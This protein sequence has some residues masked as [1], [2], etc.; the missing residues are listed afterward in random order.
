[1]K[2]ASLVVLLGM[3]SACDSA[4]FKADEATPRLVKTELFVATAPAQ[5]TTPSDEYRVTFSEPSSL[6]DASCFAVV[7]VPV[8]EPASN[9]A[10][11]SEL[12]VLTTNDGSV[13]LV[14][15]HGLTRETV[16]NAS[17]RRVSACALALDTKGQ[18]QVIVA[19]VAGD[20]S[21]TVHYRR[22]GNGWRP[23][24]VAPFAASQIAFNARG[25]RGSEVI[26][27]DAWMTSV[28]ALLV[29]GRWQRETLPT[30]AFTGA[31]ALAVAVTVGVDG[32]S[33]FALGPNYYGDRGDQ[34]VYWPSGVGAQAFVS[35]PS[36]GLA[37]VIDP[38]DPAQLPQIIH[39]RSERATGGGDLVATNLYRT[40]IGPDSANTTLWA[41]ATAVM[42]YTQHFAPEPG[43]LAARIDADGHLHTLAAVLDARRLGSMWSVDYVHDRDG[44]PHHT[45][46]P[47]VRATG[48]VA[49]VGDDRLFA[50]DHCEL[51]EV[52]RTSAFAE[53]EPA[54]LSEPPSV[55][56][57]DT[58]DAGL[59][60]GPGTTLLRHMTGLSAVTL[61]PASD[62]SVRALEWDYD[63]GHV[64][65]TTGDGFGWDTREVTPWQL[66]TMSA[67]RSRMVTLA[68]SDQLVWPEGDGLAHWSNVSGHWVRSSP[69]LVNVIGTPDLMTAKTDLWLSAIHAPTGVNELAREGRGAAALE[70]V[71][72]RYNR[73]S[74]A[75]PEPL[76]VAGT[77]EA[78]DLVEAATVPTVLFA[79]R[80]TGAATAHLVLA[81]RRG[82]GTWMRKELVRDD[83][84]AAVPR[85]EASRILGV[86]AI[87]D[88]AGD[89]IAI[90]T[91]LDV[92]GTSIV[93]LRIGATTTLELGRWS[94]I[95]GAGARALRASASG[96]GR[97]FLAWNDGNAL[98]V[99]IVSASA[100]EYRTL[101]MPAGAILWTGGV[102]LE[103]RLVAVVQ[104]ETTPGQ[105]SV[106][107]IG[108]ACVR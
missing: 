98:E 85:F 97:T 66:D 86:S 99:A 20:D 59:G 37:I 51:V 4:S 90:V 10:F 91:V 69:A 2:I 35:D 67:G 83:G 19:F 92:S 58:C 80:A 40:V 103:G 28:H 53:V 14:G 31:G 52:T 45:N 107:L 72:T 100:L 70:L 39:A 75:T 95:A 76:P 9:V 21:E 74:W 54:P 88:E 33:H 17:G 102:T 29:D 93:A 101:R 27:V 12:A 87:S 43:Q 60:F 65:Q 26:V 1:M 78:H 6:G 5:P 57:V 46:L 63:R 13:T 25:P 16:A 77:P 56:A 106:D 82:D 32:R 36:G 22:D 3:L 18:P 49:F 61:A 11:A 68:G 89:I 108:E 104:Q 73:G 15:S 50:S 41:K 23:T 64:R 84:G 71:V 105:R 42:G 24:Q 38:A 30:S 48:G 55:G 79:E 94:G 62:A 81:E 44:A 7:D 47:D 34:Y 96:D 8:D